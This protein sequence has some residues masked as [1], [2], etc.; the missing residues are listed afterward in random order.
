MSTEAII[1][2]P[3]SLSPPSGGALAVLLLAETGD[4]ETTERGL[5]SS[6]AISMPTVQKE[7]KEGREETE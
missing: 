7:V 2:P 3:V 4:P 5:W 1:A 6:D